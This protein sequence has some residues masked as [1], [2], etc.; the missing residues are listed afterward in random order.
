MS[1]SPGASPAA[2]LV[3]STSATIEPTCLWERNCHVSSC[4]Q[5]STRAGLQQF[6]EGGGGGGSIPLRCC[7]VGINAI[8]GHIN[9]DSNQWWEK[10]KSGAEGPFHWAA[11]VWSRFNKKCSHRKH[12]RTVMCKQD[13]RW[14]GEER[15][16][17]WRCTE[18]DSRMCP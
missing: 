9:R 3:F 2:L 7:M 8:S 4:P 11:A 15:Y 1:C 5:S 14:S 6:I 17:V 16:K 10:G 13:Q 18:S 12:L